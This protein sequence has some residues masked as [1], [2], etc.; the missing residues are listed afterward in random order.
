[1]WTLLL[2][3][4]LGG[5]AIALQALINARLQHAAGNPILAAT[6][7]FGVGLAGLLLALSLYTGNTQPSAL[8]QAPWFA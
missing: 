7:S 6:I 5:I 3:A 2:L 1:M 4:A 8:S